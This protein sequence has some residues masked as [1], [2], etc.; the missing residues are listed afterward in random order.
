MKLLLLSE[1]FPN[2][3][4]GEISGGVEAR[5]FYLSKYFKEELTIFSSKSYKNQT[6]KKIFQAQVKRLG[7]VY[8]YTQKTSL[9]KRLIFTFSCILH[10]P[11]H[12]DIVEGTNFF[13]HFAAIM[14]SKMHKKQIVLW[15]PDVW[16][17][18]W[19][20]NVGAPGIFGEI[21]ER[22]NLKLGKNAK[23]IS[24]SESTKEKLMKYGIPESNIIVIPCGVD[25]EEISRVGNSRNH[26]LQ[27]KYDFVIVNRLVNYKKTEEVVKSLKNNTLLIIG[28]GPEKE[29][30]DKQIV[31]NNLQG[32]VKLIPTIKNH[33]DLFRKIASAKIFVSASS[34]E[35]FNISALEAASLGLPFLLSTIPAHLEHKKNLG[36]GEIFSDTVDLS[37]KMKLL[38][39]DKNLYSGYSA[40][41][42]KNSKQYFWKTIIRNTYLF[43]RKVF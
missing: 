36:G 20:K 1:F 10:A 34:V 5:N 32:K 19:V 43:H 14:I 29:N 40:L 16:M 25:E 4:S 12:F 9:I 31:E 30:L 2:S 39:N 15:Y 7:L 37:K 23:Y 38:L 8:G 26:S 3:E 33:S 35:G 17:G 41:N 24:I 18:E 13:T 11:K 6:D 27:I 42:L 22:I 21:L 28:D